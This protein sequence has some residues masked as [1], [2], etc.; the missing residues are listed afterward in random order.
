[1]ASDWAVV[2]W[3]N[4]KRFALPA[5]ELELDRFLRGSDWFPEGIWPELTDRFLGD[6]TGF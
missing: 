5:S 2:T 4:C 6:L 3:G 1:M